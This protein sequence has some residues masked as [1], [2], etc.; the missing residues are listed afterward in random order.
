MFN[1]DGNDLTSQELGWE[2]LPR[3][4]LGLYFIIIE[5]NL[6]YVES[7]VKFYLSLRLGRILSFLKKPCNFESVGKSCL[8]VR[9]DR[10]L[11]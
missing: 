10:S 7:V 8:S 11:S 6:S 2:I 4:K 1:Y 3:Y 9:L 5:K